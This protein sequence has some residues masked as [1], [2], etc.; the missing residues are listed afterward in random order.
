MRPK[1]KRRLV[2]LTVAAAT[3]V[4][5]VGGL[6][7]YRQ[8]QIQAKLM[9]WRTKGMEAAK[10]GDY[11]E[12]LKDLSQYVGKPQ[13][14]KDAEALLAYGDARV[15]VSEANRRNIVEG[16]AVYRRYLDLK[17]DD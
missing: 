2:V 14:Q 10:A 13:A 1:T 7:Q 17:P 11:D 16:I 5:S 15:R 4:G 8:H 9:A 3:V 12:A 6:Y